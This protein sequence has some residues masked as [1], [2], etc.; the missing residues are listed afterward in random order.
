MSTDEV[1]GSV[2]DHEPA[3]QEDAL[4]CPSNPYSAAKAAAEMMCHAYEKSFKVPIIIIRCNN[5]IS[6][7]QHHEKLI[8]QTIRRILNNEKVPVHGTGESKRT[9]IH[10]YDIADAIDTIIDRGTVGNI[11]NIGTSHERTVLDV[12]QCIVTL[13]QVNN[14]TLIKK[15]T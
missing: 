4:F 12:I 13:W 11:Y 3:R 2:N 15:M 1:Y 5:A 10:A 6:K 14:V 8:P 9:F 7:Y